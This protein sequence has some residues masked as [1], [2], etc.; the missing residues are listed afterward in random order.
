MRVWLVNTNNEFTCAWNTRADAIQYFKELCEENNW[1]YALVD[2]KEE[3]EEACLEYY[4][5]YRGDNFSQFFVTIWPIFLN[6][7]PYFYA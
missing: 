1:K 7:K 3:D 2:G 4:V 5:V 6:K